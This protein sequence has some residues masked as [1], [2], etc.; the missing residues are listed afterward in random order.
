MDW[1]EV[2]RTKRRDLELVAQ[3]AMEQQKRDRKP[4]LP[5]PFPEGV[6][7]GSGVDLVDAS[8]GRLRFSAEGIT[9]SDSEPTVAA[10]FALPKP[11]DMLAGGNGL[12]M[13]VETDEGSSSEVRIGLRLT[14]EAGGEV[15][16]IL[17]YTPVVSAWGEN[18]HEVYFD[19]AFINYESVHD[20]IA[21]LQ[22]VQEV[23]ILL[24]ARQR[25][26]QRGPSG[27]PQSAAFEVSHLR[28]VDYLQGSY[29]P[30]RH[31]WTEEKE[32]DLTLQHRCQE[33]TG[34]V[35]SFGG[36]EGRKSAVESLD[37][38]ARTQCWDGSLLD[39]RRGARTVVSG[40]YTYG[41]TTYGTLTGYLAL[42]AASDPALDAQIGFG[43]AS[44]TRREAYQQM[45][46][47][48]AVSRA[49]IALPETYRDDI[50]STNTLITGANRVLGYAIAMRMV[51]DAL[52][53]DSKRQEVLAAYDPLMDAIVD[54]QGKFSGGFPLLA[55][56]DR[57]EGAGI[58]YDNGYIRTHMDWLILG[59]QRTGDPRF[60]KILERYQ[61]VFE[62]V[63]D[64]K[65]TGLLPLH[66]E[67]KARTQVVR[68]IL[69][70][71]TYQVGVKH[72]LPVI[73][74][75]GWNCSRLAWDHV[76][77]PRMNFW[78]SASRMRGYS[79]GAF[80][81]RLL[82]D[83]VPEPQPEDPGYL[84][85]RQFPIWSSRLFTREGQL[86]RTTWMTV[87]PDGRVENDFSI[88]VGQ[89]L[90]T[91]G[92]PVSVESREGAV[93]VT[94]HELEGWP[95]L[96]Q[97]GA[98]LTVTAGGRGAVSLAAGSPMELSVSGETQVEIGGPE[99]AL[100]SAAGGGGACF[101]AVLSLA[102]VEAGRTL[103]VTIRVL[104]G[105]GACVN[106][107]TSE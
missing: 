51:A 66:S 90:E 72:D 44:L 32:P 11:V 2:Q 1:Q 45:F 102:P 24:G 57:F 105:K 68:L 7:S 71:S 77:E 67:R 65:G 53:D 107:D 83:M 34:V 79:L 62:A 99:T 52:D 9:G 78:T 87:H 31:S 60:V 14:A 101:R 73:A 81:A 41:F 5:I 47:R 50:I 43:Q 17:P 95:A 104:C 16:T 36:E 103:R 12:A 23:E 63:M 4:T 19:W 61:R 28:L 46:F 58:H 74:Q 42:E 56:G 64:E 70:D 26:P 18:P 80:A 49:G 39:G 84:F 69:P 92:V 89:Y 38:C 21:V 86:V 35:A 82:D 8:A 98:M 30:A 6:R 29:D 48:A 55:E 15:A 100:P 40:E 27:A 54:A 25:A 106:P 91:V 59:V 75:W 76:E 22:S 10:R 20:A 3:H 13:V 93:A 96:L 33:V 37:L 97:D 85:P 94:A 88:E